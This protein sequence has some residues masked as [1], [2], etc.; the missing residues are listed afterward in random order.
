MN[1]R[2]FWFIA[3]ESH[4][5][6][7]NKAL[8]RRID[9]E[10]LVLF[11]GPDGKPTALQDRCLHRSSQLSR[12]K[13][14]DGKIQCPYHGWTYDASGSVVKIPSEGPHGRSSK[15]CAVTYPVIEQDDYIYVRLSL[16]AEE[17]T[18]PFPMPCYR[19]KGYSTIRLQNTFRN[20]ITNCAENFV[21]I[22]HTGF[23]HPGIFRD[24]SNERITAVVERQEASVKVTYE[25]E[26]KNF[27]IFTWFLNPKGLPVRHTD[28][29]FAPNITTV[30]YWFGN[31]HFIITS[32]SV[33]LD[34][35][36]SLVYTDLT[37]NYGWW[38]LISGGVVRR[39]GQAIIDQDIDVLDNQMKTIK[40]YGVH[41]Q[42]SPADVIHTYIESIQAEIAAGRDPSEL[43]RRETRIEFWI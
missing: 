21:D 2:S 12:G 24:I 37:Y 22:P 33:P 32:Q 38:N 40:K 4:E 13:V 29:F 1:R 23:V 18:K 6:T 42:N 34:D 26:K 36:N 39:Q 17:E 19:K 25:G 20:N 35:E 8:A 15:K 10:W 28:E 9:D 11:R 16:Q 7:Q 41:F 30:N 31:K 14:I 27:G 43:P 3:A 5:L